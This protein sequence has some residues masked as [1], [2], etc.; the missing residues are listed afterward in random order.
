MMGV[1]EYETKTQD[2]SDLKGISNDY[3][4]MLKLFVNHLNYCFVYQT[5]KNK[6]V[7]LTKDLLNKNNNKYNSNFKTKWNENEIDTFVLN[8]KKIIL[9]MKCDSLI[10]VISGRGNRDEYLI[11]SEGNKY[12]IIKIFNEFNNSQ[13][14]FTQLKNRPKMFVLDLCQNNSNKDNKS[15]N[16]KNTK[17]IANI[18]EK[19]DENKA[20]QEVGVHQS[21]PAGIKNENET[22]EKKQN[23][24]KSTTDKDNGIGNDKADEF[25]NFCIISKNMKAS[26]FSNDGIDEG[27]YLIRGFKNS[28][29]SVNS[30]N[31]YVELSHLIELLKHESLALITQEEKEWN[32]EYSVDKDMSFQI[33]QCS[34]CDSKRFSQ[35]DSAIDSKFSQNLIIEHRTNI[36]KMVFFSQNKNNNNNNINDNN[37]GEINQSIA[38]V[39]KYSAKLYWYHKCFV[40]PN[41]KQFKRYTMCYIPFDS[42]TASVNSFQCSF[43]HTGK[44]IK[45]LKNVVAKLNSAR[46][47]QLNALIQRR[48]SKPE[49]VK[50]N[51][52]PDDREVVT[53]LKR[54][55][56]R[57]HRFKSAVD[58]LAG[59]LPFELRVAQNTA[60][61]MMK[62]LVET[63]EDVILCDDPNCTSPR[64]FHGDR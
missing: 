49:K 63:E 10:F 55:A 24:D 32:T 34:H 64:H 26:D 31:K 11:D 45:P 54:I 59:Q 39:S 56:Q 46:L 40:N 48:P 14:T 37:N 18:E 38:N 22:D 41:D 16:K 62:H 9:K 50:P 23:E 60:H 57:H 52:F 58:E 27:G 44:C 1:G 3:K 19:S 15:K 17:S 8:C 53:E 61:N 36:D 5:N 20:S 7:Y 33:Y 35:S 21:S 28:L 6:M 47:D 13:E 4:N 29:K 2:F 43:E 51:K 42:S 25:S 30:S 12:Q